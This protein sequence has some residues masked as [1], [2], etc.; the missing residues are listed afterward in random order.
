[1]ILAMAMVNGLCETNER[2]ALA[3]QAQASRS[4]SLRIF[5]RRVEVGS[6]SRLQ[7][8]QVQ[9]L[10][11]QAQSL[12]AEL[13]QKRAIQV[14][15]LNLLVGAPINLDNANGRLRDH[16][17]MPEIR[18]GLPSALLE[19]RP[20]IIASEHQLRAAHANVEAARAA[21][22]P[23]IALTAG[24]GDTSLELSKLFDGN[25]K[26]WIFA[27]TVEMPIFDGGRR[28]N[29]LALSEAR[30]REALASY[31]KAIQVAFRDVNDAL[32][33]RQWLSAQLVIAANALQAQTERAR[34][35]LL[36][37]DAGSSAFLEVL[38]AQRDLL[39]T[40]QQAVQI[41]GALAMSKVALY[42][43]LGGGSLAD[44][45][46]ADESSDTKTE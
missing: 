26:A 8:T 38:D 34:L 40:E 28:K 36:R 14:H 3:K 42:T 39:N 46:D 5:T 1:M 27:P 10:L 17:N 19:S 45:D 6:S 9:T 23:R 32:A 12:V 18:A 4:E 16:T 2:L 25:S 37:F 44:E 24:I 30:Q 35:S 31:T 22:F 11:S 29:N 7:L 13:A 21:F 41:Q 20:D 33:T 43:A 15:A